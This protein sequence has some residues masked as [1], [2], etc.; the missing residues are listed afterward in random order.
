MISEV[1]MVGGVRLVLAFSSLLLVGRVWWSAGR[2]I[3]FF[4][5]AAG[6]SEACGRH[7]SRHQ[8]HRQL[9]M[10]GKRHFSRDAEVGGGRNVLHP[11]NAGPAS[12]TRLAS[13]AADGIVV[14]RQRDRSGARRGSIISIPSARGCKTSPSFMY[15]TGSTALTASWL[16]PINWRRM[17]QLRSIGF[18]LVRTGSTSLTELLRAGRR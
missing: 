5:A 2:S 12:G 7:V 17:G 10:A 16:M 13:S 14:D 1:P 4:G 15:G 9:P 18:S 6:C 8:G 3:D 11:R